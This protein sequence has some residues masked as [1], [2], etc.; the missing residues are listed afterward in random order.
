M[1][2]NVFF[3]LN[4]RNYFR[5]IF[6]IGLFLMGMTGCVTTTTQEAKVIPT[7][8]SQSK[9]KGVY[10]KVKPKETIWRI[11]KTYNVSVE[12]LVKANK[13]SD[14]SKVEK[15]QSILIPGAT[16]RKNIVLDE[17]GSQ[18]EF[19]W[20]IKG[21]IVRYFK[22]HHRGQFNKGIDIQV[23]EGELVKAARTGRVVFADYLAGYA[24]TVI[25]DHSD[26][27]YSVYARNAELLIKVGDLVLKNNEIARVGKIGNIAYLHFEI[28]RNAIADNP[29]Y[30]LQ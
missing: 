13:I 11:A 8:F 27:F 29:L 30:Y 21:K 3:N 2:E 19:I 4:I 12:D 25:L 9:K 16:S 18:K 7:H 6:F 24:Y 14:I 1:K 26:G 10:H 17:K 5:Y 28:R 22:Q 23:H 15:G 20:P